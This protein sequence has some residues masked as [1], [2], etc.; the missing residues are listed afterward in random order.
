MWKDVS[1]LGLAFLFVWGTGWRLSDV[2]SAPPEE[3]GLGA[4][5]RPSHPQSSALQS[6]KQWQ[7]HSEHNFLLGFLISF[8]VGRRQASRPLLHIQPPSE[9]P[10][11]SPNPQTLLRPLLSR[12]W[13]THYSLQGAREGRLEVC[14]QAA[15]THR[16]QQLLGM[17]GPPHLCLPEDVAPDVGA[18]YSLGVPSPAQHIC[19]KL[20]RAL[21]FLELISVNLLLCPWRKEIRSLKVSTVMPLTKGVPGR[22]QGSASRESSVSIVPTDF[23]AILQLEKLRA[24]EANLGSPAI[25]Q[26]RQAS[27][28]GSAALDHEVTLSL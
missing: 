18:T 14:G 20:V 16:A 7:G 26:H 13:V 3:T 17:E 27:N 15:P 1:L 10:W 22:G 6:G 9:P 23:G 24:K 12:C 2:G 11:T 25:K 8:G 5:Q 28:S 21:E 19:H 4:E